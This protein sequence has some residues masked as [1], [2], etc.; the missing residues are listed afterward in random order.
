[1]RYLRKNNT[2]DLIT[3]TPYW[4]AVCWPFTYRVLHTVKDPEEQKKLGS[5][6]EL[7]VFMED[8]IVAWNY[9]A[10]K[11]GVVHQLTIDFAASCLSWIDQVRPDDWVAFWA[12]DNYDDYVTVKEALTEI[13]NLRVPLN[14]WKWAPKL[15]GQ[16]QTL[17]NDET[18]DG[19]GTKNTSIS[20]TVSAFG[21]LNS[22]VYFD[23]RYTILNNAIAIWNLAQSEEAWGAVAG[24]IPAQ[25]ACLRLKEILLRYG[26]SDIVSGSGKINVDALFTSPNEGF[27]IPWPIAQIFG[28]QKNDVGVSKQAPITLSDL[29]Y[30]WSGVQQYGHSPLET[31]TNETEVFLPSN[32]SRLKG[33]NNYET[34]MPLKGAN[35][36]SALAF[37]GQT[38]WSILHQYVVQPVNEMYTCLRPQPGSNGRVYPTIVLRQ[39]PLSTSSSLPESVESKPRTPEPVTI[40]GALTYNPDKFAQGFADKFQIAQNLYDLK[41]GVEFTTSESKTPKKEIPQNNELSR[42]FITKDLTYFGSLPTWVISES[43]IYSMS[44]NLSSQSRANFVNLTPKTSFLDNNLQKVT[45]T[46]TARAVIDLGSTTRVGAKMMAQD[47]NVIYEESEDM[48]LQDVGSLFNKLMADIYLDAHLKFSGNLRIQG[49]QQPIQ[50]G[51]NIYI[52]E[53]G[54]TLHIETVSHQ[55]AVLNNGQKTFYTMLSVTNGVIVGENSST[56]ASIGNATLGINTEKRR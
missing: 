54:I 34:S 35:V 19:S 20:M 9:G 8:D 31:S 45:T 6:V 12:F 3:A 15:V 42:Y 30:L 27:T 44:L 24:T 22:T 41:R 37:H 47:I 13:N 55:G 56:Y 43:E 48:T 11:E 32:M 40:P 21:Q 36:L 52:P 17:H 33:E 4:I 53:R 50:P 28:V 18:V 49:I 26:P 2:A 51:D 7:P 39:N 46:I 10:S 16:I 1:M 38:V 23:P 14:D 25:E 29:I 5:R